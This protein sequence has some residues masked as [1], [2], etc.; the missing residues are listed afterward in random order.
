MAINFPTSLDSFSDKTD[1]VS[2]VMA[3]DINDLQDAVEALEAKVGITSSG[4]SSSFDYK[5]NNFF[6][7]GRKIYLY[8]DTAPTGWSVVAVTDRVLAV[9]GGSAAYNVAGGN[10]AGTW[11]QP[12]HTLTSDEIP[13]HTHTQANSVQL[14]FA[15]GGTVAVVG[16]A[17]SDTSGATGGGSAHSHGNTYRPYAAVGIIASKD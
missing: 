16:A 9:K 1:N 5:V 4:V 8:E 3:V 10:Q 12:D 13:S 6:A 2:A 11:T 17:L 7:T 14:G 15:G